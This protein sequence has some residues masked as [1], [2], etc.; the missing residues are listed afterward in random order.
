MPLLDAHYVSKDSPS[1]S[2][3]WSRPLIACLP[4]P[5]QQTAS[6]PSYSA[7]RLTEPPEEGRPPACAGGDGGASVRAGA[8][9][10]ARQPVGPA[11]IARLLSAP[12]GSRG[13][14]PLVFRHSGFKRLLVL[15]VAVSSLLNPSFFSFC[16]RR[17]ADGGSEWGP[18][19]GLGGKHT[20][21][22]R[23]GKGP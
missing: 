1:F 17:E 16:R 4:P 20:L 15:L 3:R 10:R 7:G 5:S 11:G 19:S 12:R 13:R 9:A 18:G 21:L 23:K 14:L 22:A 8:R 6:R 2:I